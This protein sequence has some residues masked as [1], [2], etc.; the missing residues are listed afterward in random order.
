MSVHQKRFKFYFLIFCFFLASLYVSSFFGYVLQVNNDEMYPN[1]QTK[2]LLWLS[3]KS[4]YQLGDVVLIENSS[5]LN[6]KVQTEYHLSRILGVPKD[7]I[8]M[9]SGEIF[10]N[11]QSL[12]VSKQIL[13][14]KKEEQK[15]IWWEKIA[16]KTY[17]VLG[18]NLLVFW[19]ADLPLSTVAEGHYFTICD[20]RSRCLQDD[21]L[22]SKDQIIGKIDQRLF[23]FQWFG[24]SD[25]QTD[26]TYVLIDPKIQQNP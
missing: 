25:A 23:K 18:K 11:G 12:R 1:F 13:F 14:Q 21:H 19:Q 17:A 15:E 10:R 20:H 9:K 4:E 7:Q 2:E 6:Q 22:I 16:Q 26:Q 3:A 5:T 24:K 8:E